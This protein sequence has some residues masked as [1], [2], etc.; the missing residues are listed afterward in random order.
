MSI[1]SKA[2]E[3]DIFSKYN[4]KPDKPATKKGNKPDKPDKPDTKKQNTRIKPDT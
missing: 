3:N 4:R 1:A 2:F